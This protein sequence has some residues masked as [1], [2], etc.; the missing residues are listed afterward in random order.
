M[1]SNREMY[2]TFEIR[3]VNPATEQEIVL[4]ENVGYKANLVAD[5]ADGIE[6]TGLTLDTT[7]RYIVDKLDQKASTYGNKFVRMGKEIQRQ[8][9]NAAMIKGEFVGVLS[10]GMGEGSALRTELW[11][12]LKNHKTKMEQLALVLEDD[13]DE[14]VF[15]M[16]ASRDTALREDA[17]GVKQLQNGYYELTV[18]VLDFF[19]FIRPGTILFR[20]ICDRFVLN[21]ALKETVSSRVNPNV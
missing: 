9:Q 17:I 7:L 8:K 4:S 18:Y 1:T 5:I 12:V 10:D 11:E 13:R 6:K 20:K 3:H 19:Y 14:F 2:F 16:D 15:C 21:R